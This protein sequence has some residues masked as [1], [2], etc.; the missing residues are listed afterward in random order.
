MV[1]TL[2]RKVLQPMRMNDV[3]KSI[4]NGAVNLDVIGP[5]VGDLGPTG[6]RNLMP[7]DL[8]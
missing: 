5:K 4:R 6:P 3:K 1:M 7:T 8:V 2:P